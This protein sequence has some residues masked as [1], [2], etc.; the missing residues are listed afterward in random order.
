MIV[1]LGWL[2]F[3]Y[4]Y[5][6][7][8]LFGGVGYRRSVSALSKGYFELE[9][10]RFVP[11]KLSLNIMIKYRISPITGTSEMSN[12]QPERPMS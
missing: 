7:Y 5:A 11:G 2:Y 9:P 12:H 3:I 10:K 6:F 8:R 4:K 1:I